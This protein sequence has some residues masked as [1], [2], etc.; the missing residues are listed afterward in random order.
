[1][2]HLKTAFTEESKRNLNRRQ[3]RW[4]LLFGRIN[5]K[6]PRVLHQTVPYGTALLGGAVAQALRARL[7]SHRPCG[8][9]ATCSGDGFIDDIFERYQ[10]ELKCCNALDFDD[11]LRITVQLFYRG[12]QTRIHGSA[13]SIS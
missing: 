4:E 6:N 13:S 8:T 7:R 11:L 3:R 1:L 12:E 5:G 10:E 9:F 2:I